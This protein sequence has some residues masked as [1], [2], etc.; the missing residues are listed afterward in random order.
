MTS[1]R[2]NQLPKNLRNSLH[3][4]EINGQ[5]LLRQWFYSRPSFES[6][7]SATF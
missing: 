5:E 7:G 1:F 6:F 4:G 2:G 3:I